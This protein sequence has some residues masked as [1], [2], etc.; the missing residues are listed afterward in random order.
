MEIRDT[1]QGSASKEEET[2]KENVKEQGAHEIAKEM[3][4]EHGERGARQVDGD[5]VQGYFEGNQP[6]EEEPGSGMK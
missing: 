2:S 3:T 5:D 6:E 1:P 4:R